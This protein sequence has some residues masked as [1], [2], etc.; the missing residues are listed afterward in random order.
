MCARLSWVG[1]VHE[2]ECG[3]LTRLSIR[4]LCQGTH[5]QC[6]YGWVVY[7]GVSAGYLVHLEHQS[8]VVPSSH[9]DLCQ[10]VCVCM[11]ACL[12]VCVCVFIA[13]SYLS[14]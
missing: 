7:M 3:A 12:R 6:V 13:R 11:C 2:C 14:V 8:R 10:C 4:Q 1:G 9:A 5:P